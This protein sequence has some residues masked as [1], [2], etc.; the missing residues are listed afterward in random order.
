MVI[1]VLC[2]IIYLLGVGYTAILGSRDP[3]GRFE[4]STAFLWPVIVLIWLLA[5]IK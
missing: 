1:S 2:G 3:E 4:L 5:K